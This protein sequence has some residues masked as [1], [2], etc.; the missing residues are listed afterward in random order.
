MDI[1]LVQNPAYKFKYKKNNQGQEPPLQN[2]ALY[3]LLKEELCFNT[4]YFNRMEP[5][6]LQKLMQ[7]HLSTFG[8]CKVIFVNED[9]VLKDFEGT[10]EKVKQSFDSDIRLTP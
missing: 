3:F 4:K 1:H 5:L 10:I 2:Y 9:D 7:K 6:G 8:T